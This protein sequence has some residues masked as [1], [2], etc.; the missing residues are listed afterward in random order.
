MASR[1]VAHLKQ[2]AAGG[3]PGPGMLLQLLRQFA[4]GPTQQAVERTIVVDT[5]AQ[6]KK[7]ESLGMAREQA[8]QLTQ[9]MT[10]QIVMDRVRLTERFTAKTELEKVM[11]IA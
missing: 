4:S 5:L 9:H 7:F 3:V 1:A 2:Y 11:A 8:E 6:T 10:E